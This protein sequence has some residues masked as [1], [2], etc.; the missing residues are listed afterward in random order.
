MVRRGLGSH[1]DRDMRMRARS[2]LAL[3][4]VLVL[5]LA[6]LL[7]G[8]TLAPRAYVVT[9]VGTNALTVTSNFYTGE[10]LFDSS[11]PITDASGNIAL[12][13]PTYYHALN[14]F[15]RSAN[16]T[17]GLPYAVGTLQA[18]V[19]DQPRSVYSSGLGDGAIRFSVNLK[20][21]PA[22]KLPQFRKWK[23]KTVVGISLVVQFPSGQY[24]PTKLINIGT[25][26]WGFKP[27]VGFSRRQGNWLVDVYGGVWFFTANPEF[28][29]RNS[30]FPGT[31]SQTQAP[32]GVIAGHLSYDFKPRL[33][34]SLDGN[35]W[36]GGR[37][38]L[39]GVENRNSLQRDSRI[40]ATA[41]IPV[42]RHQTLKFSYS[43]GV[44]VRG[45]GGNF[46]A[47]AFAWQYGW[48]GNPFK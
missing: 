23:Q 34:V 38:T 36:Y 40:G 2:R 14:F 3:W 19:V 48:I 41:A 21:G 27:E 11:V 12:I 45:G 9:P 6:P 7:H 22:M 13:V 15:G 39:N 4:A 43:R 35:F 47:F 17:I 5:F 20:G 42:S 8:Q 25:N 16:I 1:Y 30:F 18:L 10:V 28:F 37:T 29:S 33:W 31:R 24:D 32:I 26:R 46:Q 44:Y